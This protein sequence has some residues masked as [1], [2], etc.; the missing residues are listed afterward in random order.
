MGDESRFIVELMCKR[1]VKTDFQS[2]DLPRDPQTH[3]LKDYYKQRLVEELLTA[4]EWEEICQRVLSWQEM[5]QQ[6][7]KPILSRILSRF[8]RFPPVSRVDEVLGPERALAYKSA[9]EAI[10]N[11]GNTFGQ[12]PAEMYA[13]PW[14]KFD[15]DAAV[16]VVTNVIAPNIGDE[17]NMTASYQQLIC[18]FRA[19]RRE[20][21][22]ITAL[23][24]GKRKSAVRSLGIWFP[25]P[26]DIDAWKNDPRTHMLMPEFIETMNQVVGRMRMVRSF[27]QHIPRRRLSTR[28]CT[29]LP[30]NLRRMKSYLKGDA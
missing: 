17:I 24:F 2:G 7:N 28:A 21:S 16:S 8:G 5:E 27:L 9:L 6:Q 20:R 1:L 13:Y 15:M 14:R 4:E 23:E 18:E 19:R 11:D 12:F 30:A 3:V 10:E 22:S 25:I 29:D 26:R